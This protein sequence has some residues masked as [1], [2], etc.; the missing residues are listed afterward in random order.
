[1]EP[2][3]PKW[4]RILFLYLLGCFIGSL[5]AMGVLGGLREGDSGTFLGIQY[6]IWHQYGSLGLAGA[7][8]GALYALR[9]FHEF[10]GELTGRWVY[11]YFMRP[12]LCFGSAILTV[13]LFESGILLLQI[14]DSMQARISIAF[15]TG[16]GF[17]KFM[18]KIRTLTETFLNGSSSNQN[19]GPGPGDGR[20]K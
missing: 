16:F 3:H 2:V 13:I 8:G 5:W 12:L 1:M 17:G 4:K 10:H 11:W 9:M 6:G 19:G 20:S 15:L 18:E 14:G 7:V